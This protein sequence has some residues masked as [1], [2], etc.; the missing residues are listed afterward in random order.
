M[1]GDGPAG[2]RDDRHRR[3]YDHLGRGEAGSLHAGSKE[4]HNGADDNGSGTAVLIGRR[5]AAG[6]QETAAADCVHR[7]Y[8]RRTGTARQR[9]TTFTIRCFRSSKTVA[10]LNMDMVGRLKNDD[11]TVYGTGTAKEF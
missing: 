1:E 7:L 9:R 5:A 2:R 8:R 4:I 6:G 11:L 3:H 10:M